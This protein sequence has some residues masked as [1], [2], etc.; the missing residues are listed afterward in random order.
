M[1]LTNIKI[2]RFKRLEQVDFDV[3]GVNIL[4]GGNNSG[5]ST[6]IQ[7]AHFAFTLLQSLNISNKWPAKGSK[8]STV[9]PSDLV[10]VPSEDPYSLGYG[11]RLLEDEKRSIGVSFTFDN[12]EELKVAIRK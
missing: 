3:E 1:K 11:G 8:S 9:S 10:Y 4:I 2:E 5:K 7:A 6:I 12:G